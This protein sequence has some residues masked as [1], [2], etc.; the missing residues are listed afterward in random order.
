MET[1][2]S[3]TVSYTTESNNLSTT[4]SEFPSY[5]SRNIIVSAVNTGG[6][7]QDGAYKSERIIDTGY[8][9]NWRPGSNAYKNKVIAE[10]NKKGVK[11]GDRKGIKTGNELDSLKE[12]NNKKIQVQKEDQ[13][14]E[15]EGYK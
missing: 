9:P 10:R 14:T 6:G 11:L 3:G 7:E 12:L 8:I 4:V 2:P 13:R 1:N 15:K 5:V